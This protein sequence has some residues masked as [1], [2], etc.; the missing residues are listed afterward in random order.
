[1]IYLRFYFTKK[2]Q[3]FLST[4]FKNQMIIFLSFSNGGSTT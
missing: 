1:M 2:K 3:H 4:V